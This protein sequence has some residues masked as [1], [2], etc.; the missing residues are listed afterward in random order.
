MLS[1]WGPETGETQ[2]P[3]TSIGVNLMYCMYATLSGNCDK[4]LCICH[5]GNHF[6]KSNDCKGLV[7]IHA[8][9]H[10]MCIVQTQQGHACFHIIR[11]SPFRILIRLSPVSF[12][13]AEL[14]PHFFASSFFI[15]SRSNSGDHTGLFFRVC[16]PAGF[17]PWLEFFVW[18]STF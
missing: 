13:F 1:I 3:F 7:C 9:R 16:W 4:A 5:S 14:L 15:L 10:P 8:F 17:V 11:C 18:P 2:R 12:H 6:L